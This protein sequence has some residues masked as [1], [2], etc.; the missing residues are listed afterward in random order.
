M[1]GERKALGL[2]GFVRIFG[3]LGEASMSRQVIRSSAVVM[4]TGAT[5][6]GSL[7]LLL[8]GSAEGQVG[9]PKEAPKAAPQVKAKVMDK[10]KKGGPANPDD[11][12]SVGE[13]G[14]VTLPYDRDAK[15]K[16][17]AARDYIQEK[18]WPKA[19]HVLQGL[20]KP[21]KEDVMI[22]VP[23]KGPDGRDT[24]SWVSVREEANRMIGSL[25]KEGMEFYRL[26]NNQAA[27]DLLKQAKEASDERLLA[28]VAMSYLHTDAGAEAAELLGTRKLDRGDFV[29]AALYF[30]RLID[31]Q[32]ADKLSPLTLFKAKLAFSRS[33]GERD[34]A[35]AALVS[36]Q[37]EARAPNGLVL[38]N[39][40]L[41]LA[42]L[43]DIITKY[44]D[45]LRSRSTIYDWYLGLGGRADRN[46]Q[47]VGGP[48]F[49]EKEWEQP[50]FVTQ[51]SGRGS[52]VG[53]VE[54]ALKLLDSR[55]LPALASF[56]PI[57]A[58][59]N[60]P[61]KGPTPF[62][63]YRSH[64]GIHAVNI[65]TGKLEWEADM[66]WSLERMFAETQTVQGISQ[67]QQMYRQMAWPNIVLE[68]SV[69]GSLASDGQRVYCIDDLAVPPYVQNFYNNWG[70]APQFPWGQKINEAMQHSVLY[71]FDLSTGKVLWRT[72]GPAGARDS[73]DPTK[74][75]LNESY[76]LG[77]PLALG[78]K[79]YVLTDKNQELRLVCLDAA[80][81]TI[82]WIQTLA[83]T[84]EKMLMEV[85]RRAHAAPLAY[86]EG[87]LVCPTNAGAVIG[88][89]FL[90]HSLLWAYA[91]RDRSP[92]KDLQDQAMMP[93][94]GGRVRMGGA[95]IMQDGSTPMNS[96]NEWKVSPPVIAD[97]KVV[98][99]APDGS[100]IDCLNLRD[101]SRVWRNTRQD[102]D[103][104]LA[105][106]YAGR[107]LIVGKDRCRALDLKDGSQAWVLE[108]GVPSGRGV[109][110]DNIYYL[111]LKAAAAPPHDPE[112]C[113]IDVAR[114]KFVAHTK[115][116][117]KEVPG[118]LLFYEGKM[119]A[120]SATTVA[121][122]PQLKIKMQEIDERIARD[123]RDP[124]GLTDRGELRLDQ[125]NLQG[126]VDDLRAALANHP[127]TDLLPKTRAKLYEAMTDLFRD[128]FSDAEKYLAEYEAMC[129]DKGLS[130]EDRQKRQSTFLYLLAKGREDQ[131]KLVEAF[132][133][134]QKFGAQAANQDLVSVPDESTLKAPPDVWAQGRIAAMVARATP[135]ARL[136]LE[137]QIARS[138]DAVQKSG[139]LDKLRQFVAMFGSLFHAGR[140][141]RLQLA[142][143]L[144]EE[145]S[146]TSL[147]DA[148]RQLLLLRGQKDDP[149]LA[150][151]ALE[152]LARLWTRQGLL[153]D[154]A[155][156]Y[157]TLAREYAKVIVR[158]GKTGTD[159]FNEL[160]TDKRFLPYI[161][162][163]AG[164]MVFGKITGKIEHVSS[165]PQNQMVFGFEPEG[166][167]L[168]FFQRHKVA[169][170]VNM[171]Q[172]KLI[173][174]KTN[175][176]R[177]S[178]SLT[179]TQFA[180]YMYMHNP[181]TGQPLSPRYRYHMV[182]HVIVLQV[183]NLVFGLD[184]VGKR[185]LWEKNLFG[186]AGSGLPQQQNIMPDNDGALVILYTDGYQEKLGQVGPIGPAYVCIQSRG[187]GLQALDPVTGRT[188][189]T[190][191]DV[192][193]RSQLFGD[194]QYLYMVE[195]GQDG[196]VGGSRAFRASDGVSVKVPDFAA[197]YQKRV[198]TIGRNILLSDNDAKS[199][200][201]RLYDVQE[202]KDI[203]KR[204]FKANSVVLKCD[205]PHLAG[206]IEPDG[207][208]TL[209]NL[210]TQ[211]DVL[212]STIDPKHIAKAQA[213]Y[214]L[215]D[216]Q[217]YYLAINGPT[218]ANNNPFGPP[219][220]GLM[221]GSGMRS[222][223]VNG[224]FY[225][226]DRQTGKVR[227]NSEVLQQMVVLEH[228][229][230]MPILLFSSRSNRWG[231]AGPNRFQQQET[232][233]RSID[234]RTGKMLI[235]KPDIGNGVMF[236][237]L[238]MDLRAGKIELISQQLK[239]THYLP[240]SDPAAAKNSQGLQEA[241][242]S[243]QGTTSV[244]IRRLGRPVAQP[245]PVQVIEK[246]E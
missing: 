65:K 174:R 21:D 46:A 208:V 165:P 87:I 130:E 206:V 44:A 159:L 185:V 20:L 154:A 27:A 31:R 121:A 212:K 84:K 203:W 12:N 72:G 178:E 205:D 133:Y 62:M 37:L 118:N 151:R 242:S 74:G 157:Q 30:E 53:W 143:R 138:W 136:P 110:S 116:R 204:E 181:R 67:W 69:V 239:I 63:I 246:K 168:P 10:G 186:K 68:N 197:L 14:S 201:L 85:K 137:Q 141:A 102:G 183:A 167:L 124:A 93:G 86:G 17:D 145:G 7:L 176:E 234:K 162:V 233:F 49:F 152:T 184:P 106:V 215:E 3:L 142:E 173:D 115:S 243:K 70:G 4:V 24:T 123:P 202:G 9:V 150:A 244:P 223:P 58:T 164:G 82:T 81:G 241:P 117:K 192:T 199:L 104:Y 189:W 139:N 88:V 105:G 28:R 2:P 166:E 52:A 112:V 40:T 34:K 97:G 101:G 13:F 194:D 149:T 132:D 113:A 127:P 175:E 22:P 190:R 122:Y 73:H 213:V 170:N 210:N 41:S 15:K 96:S 129:Q 146:K 83:T 78:G 216:G 57:A 56:Y 218:D 198:R 103:L 76:F 147:L 48:P 236:H 214:L 222:L 114:G 45:P 155:S 161:D 188:L 177:W 235:D 25:P 187:E 92:A 169:L 8:S 131:G 35:N 98:F 225:A 179:H 54:E 94:M 51:G 119:L 19:I 66:D 219:Q 230:E 43:N 39:R 153:E 108:T 229:R 26:Q 209:V 195:V 180:N 60:V 11:P 237:A 227:W 71:A 148:E 77:P 125:G 160:A 75:E 64:S 90:T 196:T 33:H 172:F 80:K 95:M 240:N 228:F 100:T 91:Y 36:R 182:G 18:D 163:P 107:A 23:R 29:G 200:A 191:S 120:Q 221:P 144:M 50:L 61:D 238:N 171:H 47:G 128:K 232:A 193:S 220:S 126:A 217:H 38:G 111:P 16:I 79:L 226:L 109:A 59:A 140:E 245:V 158:D 224:Y 135:E 211:K 99:T 1:L 231:G 55:H 207:Q 42:D 32:G 6:V 5:F 156:C 134:Y 89:D